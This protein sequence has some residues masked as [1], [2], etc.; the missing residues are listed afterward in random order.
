MATP[1]VGEIRIFAGN[2]AP[3]GWMSCEGQLLS[4]A[5]YDTLFNLIGPTYG[6]DG[7][8]TFALPDLRGRIPMHQGAGSALG[9]T[10]GVEQVILNQNQIPAH[11]HP[12]MTAAVATTAQASGSLPAA[13]PD[14]PYST[15]TD[16]AA[17]VALG[18]HTIGA[19]GGNQPHPNMPPYLAVQFIISL[20]GI[21][22]SQS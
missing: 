1:Y 4:I 15:T 11:T 19:A 12:V 13:W 3:V 6:G 17:L 9:Q 2:F 5:E 14:T 16:P 21:Y 22:P 7:Q 8:S 18:A 10:G 20:F